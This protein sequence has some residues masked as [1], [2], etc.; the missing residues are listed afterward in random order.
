MRTYGRVSTPRTHSPYSFCISRPGSPVMSSLNGIVP[1]FSCPAKNSECLTV[2]GVPYQASQMN[3]SYTWGFLPATST[4]IT[5]NIPRWGGCEHQ[6][7]RKDQRCLADGPTPV[8]NVGYRGEFA[9]GLSKATVH[10]SCVTNGKSPQQP[11][12]ST[13]AITRKSGI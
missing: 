13:F 4:R 11:Y 1:S 5:Y 6:Q 8:N 3:Q 9:L 10:V 7:A 2:F 12:T